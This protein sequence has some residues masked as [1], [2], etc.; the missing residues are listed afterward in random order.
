M[1]DV[2]QLILT[3]GREAALQMAQT[4]EEK[5]LVE[6]AAEVMA[7]EQESLGITYSGFCLTAL[8]HREFQGERWVRHGHR[9]TLVV[10]SG[11]D[12]QGNPLGI[13]F[14]SRA[15]MILLYLQTKAIQSGSREVELGRSMNE[16]LE[17][18]GLSAGGKTYRDVKEQASRISSANLAFF[19]DGPGESEV[20]ANETIVSKA[21]TFGNSTDPRQG[22]LWTDKVELSENFFRALREHP[23]PVRDAAIR[24]ISGKSM[25]LDAYIWLAYRLHT[26]DKRTT[27]RWAALY[28]QFGAGI[29]KMFHFKPEFTSALKLAMAAYP[30]A[31]VEVEREHIIL[32]P[33]P[34]PVPKLTLV[35]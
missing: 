35:R 13:P 14:G 34:P 23:V 6:V 11:T 27:V 16:W 30:E 12:R 5:R 4:K 20:R 24:Q 8:P 7:S 19:W 21:I 17:R 33:S 3:H 28:Q 15:R 22:S 29:Q 10:Q 32:H 18:M 9:V 2:H 25:A 26:L 1:S 31:K